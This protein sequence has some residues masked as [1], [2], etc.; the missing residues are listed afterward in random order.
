[1][2]ASNEVV[3]VLVGNKSDAKREVSFDEGRKLANELDM[4]FFETSAKENM[5]V[6]DMF[7]WIGNK[8]KKLL[9]D[10]K[11]VQG[12]MSETGTSRNLLTNG[13]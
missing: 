12:K 10:E 11:T 1:M 2:H 13:G 4:Q 5:N 3:K 9:E 8:S 7:L 6:T